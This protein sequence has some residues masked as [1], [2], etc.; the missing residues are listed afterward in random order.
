VRRGESL[1]GLAIVRAPR[2][3][4]DQ[5]LRGI[6]VATL[7]DLLFD[8]A[9]E[10]SGL[11]LLGAVEQT[12]RRLDADALLASSSAASAVRLFRRQWYLPFGGTIH[13]LFRATGESGA[14]FGPTVQDWWLQRGDGGSDDAL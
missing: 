8:P 13:L 6:R 4:G 10:K 12:A 11:A 1:A 2:E 14:A 7:S 9:D 3:A 5:R